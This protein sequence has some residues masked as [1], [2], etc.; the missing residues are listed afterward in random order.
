MNRITQ[1]GIQFHQIRVLCAGDEGC[2]SGVGISGAVHNNSVIIFI[3]Q[4]QETVMF[5]RLTGSHRSCP[6]L[7]E[8]IVIQRLVF[9]CQELFQGHLLY[10]NNIA[11]IRFQ[12]AGLSL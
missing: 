10:A 2:I 4:N 8:R 1:I 11:G 12:R 7:N 9:Q 5:S 3:V 6:F